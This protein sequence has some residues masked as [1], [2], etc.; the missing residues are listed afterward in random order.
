MSNNN[1]E[2]H[3]DDNKITALYKQGS[4]ETPA[5]HINRKILD[6]ASQQPTSIFHLPI[7]L[8]INTL[9]YSK[10]LA[11]AAV[12]VIS[13]S[14][15]LQI[16]FDHP[17]QVIPKSLQ[18]KNLQETTDTIPS[19]DH[20]S[21]RSIEP[22][23]SRSYDSPDEQLPKA[24]A[25]KLKASKPALRKKHSVKESDITEDSQLHY[26]REQAVKTKK[27][28]EK[29]RRLRQEKKLEANNIL[30]RQDRIKSEASTP[31]VSFMSTFNASIENCKTLNHSEC[32]SSKSCS[33]S[34]IDEAMTC[35]LST[36]P[37]ES[38]FI[39]NSDNSETCLNRDQCQYI[40]GTCNCNSNGDCECVNNVIPTCQPNI[41]N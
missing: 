40:E 2:N 39:Q 4:I 35:Q 14:I 6:T 13:I 5:Q 23:A 17:E 15:I 28:K 3:N 26:Q 18:E 12:V 24:P 10:P 1:Q 37:C 9:S 41:T 25:E 27:N 7:R 20:S 34:Y 31:Q 30:P 21:G 32:L 38:N 19:L 29:E 36:P 11:V 16:Q 8:L 22:D 33:L